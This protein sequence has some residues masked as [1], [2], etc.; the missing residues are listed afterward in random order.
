M[1]RYIAAQGTRRSWLVGWLVGG[2][3]EVRGGSYIHRGIPLWGNFVPGLFLEEVLVIGITRDWWSENG[4]ACCNMHSSC[5]VVFLS[6]NMG[7]LQDKL[8][9]SSNTV[10]NSFV[11]PALL[12]LQTC[13]KHDPAKKIS[14][15]RA[16]C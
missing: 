5:T 16:M 8:E 15:C 2:K 4:G 12:S 13:V 3:T 11:F 7:R 14:K 1:A 6:Q 9:Y 10:Y